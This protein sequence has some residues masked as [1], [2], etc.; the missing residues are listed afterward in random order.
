MHTDANDLLANRIDRM[1][2][3]PAA[4]VELKLPVLSF[5]F[6]VTFLRASLIA[7]GNCFFCEVNMAIFACA[8]KG[9]AFNPFA[10][11]V[12]VGGD[13]S[14]G[15]RFAKI[16]FPVDSGALK[17]ATWAFQSEYGARIGLNAVLVLGTIQ[18]DFGPGFRS[19]YFRL[20]QTQR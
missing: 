12:A 4:C 20:G 13:D 10:W 5:L 14:E 15:Y 2:L 17:F 1:S 3:R 6:E 9:Q 16:R 19:V 18:T 8:V 11:W 7:A